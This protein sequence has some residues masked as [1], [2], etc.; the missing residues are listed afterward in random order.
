M[1]NKNLSR[2]KK[3]TTILIALKTGIKR[4]KTPL[5]WAFIEQSIYFQLMAKGGKLDIDIGKIDRD[6]DSRKK[7]QTFEVKNFYLKKG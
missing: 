7:R 2:S 4:G 5:P 3:P 1:R 6:P